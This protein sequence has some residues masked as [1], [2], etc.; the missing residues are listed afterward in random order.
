MAAQPQRP[1]SAHDIPPGRKQSGA[2]AAVVELP[3]YEHREAVHAVQIGGAP[4]PKP[5]DPEL[6]KP[7][8]EIE[9]QQRPPRIVQPRHGGGP[10]RMCI[11]D[12]R[13]DLSLGVRQLI[14][15]PENLRAMTHLNALREFI[16]E[17]GLEPIADRLS[18]VLAIR[19]YAASG[20][21]GHPERDHVGDSLERGLRDTGVRG[22]LR[23]PQ[24]IVQRA[25]AHQGFM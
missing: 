5:V 17:A 20:R 24:S 22:L 7:P 18:T 12:R 9:A 19:V 15:R 10:S 14:Q 6:V 21:A 16:V 2:G 13:N 8:Q 4:D 3:A 11:P 25:T 23:L 1:K